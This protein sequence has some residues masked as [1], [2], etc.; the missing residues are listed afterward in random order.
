MRHGQARTPTAMGRAAFVF[1]SAAGFVALATW[2]VFTGRDALAAGAAGAAGLFL[3]AGA[4]LVRKE[5]HGL[6]SFLDSG[7]DRAFDGCLLS[8]IALTSRQADAPA[9]GAAV[10]A[11]A[12]SFLGAYVR[13]RGLSLGYPIEEG[14]VSRAVRYGLVSVGLGARILGPAMFALLAVTLL[15]AAVRG[16]QV[17]KKERE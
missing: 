12:A 7:V 16:S 1:G 10:G 14:F 8:A 4:V 2:Q 15:A 6:L 17:A 5:G 3:L 13:A 9:A 11:L